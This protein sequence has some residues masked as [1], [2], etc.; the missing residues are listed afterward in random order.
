MSMKKF[1]VPVAFLLAVIMCVAVPI[2]VTAQI[3]SFNTGE[4]ST[5]SENVVEPTSAVEPATEAK[6]IP[7]AVKGLKVSLLESDSLLL[8]WDKSDN[9]NLYTIYRAVEEKNGK[10]GSYRK[11]SDVKYNS[12]RDTGLEQAKIYKY[13][14]FAYRVS[15]EYVTQSKSAITSVMTRPNNVTGVKLSDKKTNSMVL[16]WKKSPKADK[17]IIYRSE[18]NRDGGY[19]EYKKIREVSKG[20]KLK[21]TDKRLDDGTIYKYKVVAERVQGDASAVST[22]TATKGMTKLNAPSGFKK[23]K[24]SETAI[25]LSW[26]KVN[27]A[28]KYE[29]YRDGVKIKTIKNT[30][31]TDRKLLSGSL[32][33]YT[34]RAVRKVGKNIKR[35][36]LASLS[37]SCKLPANRIV[38]SISKQKFYLYI[39]NKVVLQS[40]VVTGM[41]GDRATTIGHHHIISRKSP[42]ILRGSYGGSSWTTR[43]NYWLGFTYSGQGFHDS[44]WRGAYGGNI[45]RSDGSHGCVNTPLDAVRKLYEKAYVGMLVIVKN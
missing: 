21:I 25:K 23:L 22:G 26:K 10:I 43:V 8:S 30:T 32:H 7:S 40:S 42:A 11:Y 6:I 33:N 16:S 3:T 15:G 41:P 9:A 34:V 38:V 44:T 39:K 24:A 14:I 17:Y 5:S 28:E 29:L 45:Y 12:F 19:T 31:Y 35:G 27:H 36:N 2:T 4:V 18:E 37:A 1:F 20:K 13:Q